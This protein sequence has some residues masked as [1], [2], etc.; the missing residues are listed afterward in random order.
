MPRPKHPV[1]L[2][3]IHLTIEQDTLARLDLIISD[4]LTGKPTL[5]ARSQIIRALLSSTLDA[6]SAGRS[7]IDISSVNKILL[8]HLGGTPTT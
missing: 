8:S 2:E 3:R 7:T 5:G 6:F 4:P 1:P